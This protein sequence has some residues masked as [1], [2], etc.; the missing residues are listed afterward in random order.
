ML[1]TIMVVDDDDAMRDN[2][3]D[4]LKE[5]G[6][7][8]FSASSCAQAMRVASEKKPCVALLD[9]KLPDASGIKLLG[10]IKRVAPDCICALM[11]AFADVDSAVEALEKGAFHYLQKPVRPIELI[12]LLDRIFETIQIREE[13]RSAEEKL[14]ESEKRFRTIFESAQD[15]IFLKEEGLKFT[16]VNPAMEKIYGIRADKFIGRSDHDVFGAEVGDRIRQTEERVLQGEIVEEEEVV[17]IEG[18][19]KTFHSIRVPLS[20]S[21][22]KIHGLCGFARDLTATRRLEAQLV[23]AQ[24]MEAIGTLAGGISHD[25]NNLL[26]AILGYTQILLMDK[27]HFHPDADKLTEIEKAAQ[28]ASALI[29][30]L[31]AFGRKMEIE[32]RPVDINQVVLQVQNLLKRTIPKMIDI[33][34][35][36]SGPPLSVI[37]DAGQLEQVLLNIG[38]NARDAMPQGGTLTFETA[39]VEPDES[40]RKINLYGGPGRYILLSITDTGHGMSEEILER[41][42]DPFF[43]TKQPGQGT[44]LGLAM[45]YGII[46]NHHGHITCLSRPGIGTTFRIY[47]PAA[48]KLAEPEHKALENPIEKGRGETIL[49]VDDEPYLRSLVREM[50]SGNGYQVLT[51]ESGEEA[52]SLYRRKS[53]SIA[54][55]LLD[56][57]MPGMGGKQCMEEILKLNPK[58]KVLISSGYTMDNPDEDKVLIRARGFIPKPY[59]FRDMMKRMRDLLEEG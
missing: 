29:K 17:W 10:D 2:L 11:T 36:L 38:V 46:K 19:Q 30:R 44:G 16:L 20:G 7:D 51:V 4:I 50:L 14:R 22:G 39:E 32:S 45:A 52:L 57:I 13:K 12:N 9:L 27:D 21:N 23:Q 40:F 18:K 42:F 24:K 47:L 37:A 58:A 55:I 56:L 59:N 15:A 53:S 49:V 3:E 43:T 34:L 41:I 25:F 31:L 33:E 1:K 6:Y 35:R 26:Q 48:D 5:E 54:L 8:L 28:R